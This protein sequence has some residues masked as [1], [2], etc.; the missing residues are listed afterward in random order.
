VPGFEL[1]LIED[2]TRRVLPVIF[3]ADPSLTF[4]SRAGAEAISD[5]K[6]REWC[7]KNYPGWL[8]LVK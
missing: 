6:A 1:T 3:A 7:A 5:A 8:M 2:G 4:A